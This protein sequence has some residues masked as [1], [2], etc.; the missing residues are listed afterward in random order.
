MNGLLG[1]VFC[2]K[3]RNVIQVSVKPFKNK[4]FKVGLS[5]SKKNCVV[6]FVESALKIMKNAFY[7]ILKLFSFSRCFCHDLL[8]M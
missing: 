1:V 5:P 8:F 6:C 2:E 7:F 3:K 4:L